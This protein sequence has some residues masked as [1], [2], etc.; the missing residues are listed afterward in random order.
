MKKMIHAITFYP[1]FDEKNTMCFQIK[2]AIEENAK[3]KWNGQGMSISTITNPLIE[4]AVRVTPHKFL[5]I[6]P[7]K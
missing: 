4:F 3:S 7:T 5:L 6:K 1:T 2:E